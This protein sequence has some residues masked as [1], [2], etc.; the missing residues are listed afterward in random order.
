MSHKYVINSIDKL[1]IYAIF[2]IAKYAFYAKKGIYMNY[3]DKKVIREQ[4]DKKLAFLKHFA[5]SGVPL[6]GWIKAIREALGLSASQL[7]KRAGIDQSRISRLENAEKNGDL[8]LS[9]LQKIAKA[10]NMKFVYGFVPDGTEDTLETMVRNQAKRIA[11]RRIETLDH[12]M[13]LEK[14]ALSVEEQKKALNDMI[15]KILVDPPKDFWD[16]DGE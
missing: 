16:R 1:S 12:T 11:L 8:K 3:W 6:Q 4:L 14:Q 9:S 13:Q 7:G 2:S 15:V 10:L 5:S